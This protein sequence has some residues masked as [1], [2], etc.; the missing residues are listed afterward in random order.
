MTDTMTAPESPA[1]GWNTAFHAL[2]T[3]YPRVRETV[4]V[5][6]HILSQNPGIALD[7]AKAQAALHGVRITAASISAA[8]RLL[9]RQDGAQGAPAPAK[10][11]AR[12]TPQRETGRPRR[13]RVA[14][15]NADP[16]AMLR[17]VADR[18]R[19]QG[20]AEAKRLRAA[21]RKAI[22]VLQAAIEA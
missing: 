17:A 15:A 14:T 1:T 10:T 8:Q 9:D 19:S 12:T 18:I 22:A 4:L 6:L 21:V 16:E 2:K 20:V 7:D 11:K 5:A 3:R 13:P